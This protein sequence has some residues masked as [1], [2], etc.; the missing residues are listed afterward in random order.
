M[1]STKI[2]QDLCLVSDNIG[3]T[4]HEKS[5]YLQLRILGT[6]FERSTLNPPSQVLATPL[7]RGDVTPKSLYLWL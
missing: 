3:Q 1:Q 5:P 6:A 7:F 2:P 4:Y